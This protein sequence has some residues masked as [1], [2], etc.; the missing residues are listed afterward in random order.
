M[1]IAQVYA[2][3]RRSDVN[4]LVLFAR[5]ENLVFLRILA[6]AKYSG[7]FFAASLIVRN[8]TNSKNNLQR[9]SHVVFMGMGEPLDNYEPVVKSLKM[10]VDKTEFGLSW[11]HVTVSTSGIA[12]KIPRLAL[13]VRSSLAVSLHA[14]RDELRSEL[15]PINRKYPLAILKDA[16]VQYQENNGRYYHVRIYLNQRQ[17]LQ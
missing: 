12:A 1:I 3:H 4:S 15:M 2:C 8:E 11:R 7:S 13:D 14:P 16:L 6:L 5:R 17:E 10:L 9:I